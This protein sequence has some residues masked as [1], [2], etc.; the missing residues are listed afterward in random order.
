MVKVY[1]TLIINKRRTFAQVPDAFKEAVASYLKECGYDTNGD[2][3][4]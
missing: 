3:I 1:S 4:V 2:L